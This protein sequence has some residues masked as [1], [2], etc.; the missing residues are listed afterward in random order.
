[1]KC[2]AKCCDC[3]GGCQNCKCAKNSSWS[4]VRYYIMYVMDEYVGGD[5]WKLFNKVELLKNAIDEEKAKR[6]AK[7]WLRKRKK[8][9]EGTFHE[10]LISARLVASIHKDILKLT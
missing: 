5:K 7:K 9:D 8:I 10:R 3:K 2:Q 1:M 4:P 6:E